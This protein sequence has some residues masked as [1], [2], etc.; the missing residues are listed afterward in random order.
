MPKIIAIGQLLLKL[1]YKMFF[2]ETRCIVK[3]II[4]HYQTGLL[5]RHHID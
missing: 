2:F 3:P 1:L 4:C 5:T